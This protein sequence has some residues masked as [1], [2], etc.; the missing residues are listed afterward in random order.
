MDN[1]CKHARNSTSHDIIKNA[2]LIHNIVWHWERCTRITI[3]NNFTSRCVSQCLYVSR[4]VIGPSRQISW[5]VIWKQ[6]H[7]PLRRNPSTFDE[8]CF[9]GRHPSSLPRCFMNTSLDT[10][11]S[12]AICQYNPRSCCSLLPHFLF[13]TVQSLFRS[14]R[15]RLPAVWGPGE[16][17]GATQGSYCRFLGSKHGFD[18]VSVCQCVRAWLPA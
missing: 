4:Y 8:I 15:M 9:D 10:V 6:R 12:E 7:R 17:S 2:I 18:C 5:P 11:H 3:K 1:T 14:N 16:G 13:I